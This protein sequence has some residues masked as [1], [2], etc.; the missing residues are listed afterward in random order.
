MNIFYLD[1]NIEECAK[2]HVD[3]HVV[4]MI[5]EH[6]Q[7]LS[8]AV[9]LSGIDAGYKVTHQN[10]P[11]AIWARESLDNWRWLKDLTEA[12]NNEYMYRYER[13][14]NHKA[15]DTVLSLPEPNIP[16]T[17]ITPFRLA[18]P[19]DVRTDD[20]V[21]AYRNYYNKYKTHIAVWTNR[22][23]PYWFGYSLGAVEV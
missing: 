16:S 21:Q 8:T 2:A 23:V 9:R 11:C 18:M 4:K 22:E 19:D 15:F 6:A 3:K 20:P 10:H 1:Y 5:T 13:F 7:L 17:G 12:L 14:N